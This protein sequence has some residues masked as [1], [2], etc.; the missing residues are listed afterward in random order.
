MKKLLLG[1]LFIILV[2]VAAIPKNTLADITTNFWLNLG[3][4]LKP[5]ANQDLG[6]SSDRIANGY[7]N[8]IDVSGCTGCGGG[9]GGTGG[10]GWSTSTPNIVYNNF[11]TVVGI[12]STTPTASLVVRGTSTTPTLPIDCCCCWNYF[13]WQRLWSTCYFFNLYLYHGYR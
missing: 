6:A 7:F 1:F 12:N 8:N 2:A 3:T 9:S 5:N 11:G 4:Y 10:A 13:I